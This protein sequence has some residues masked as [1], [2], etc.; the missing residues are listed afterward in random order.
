MENMNVA[1]QSAVPTSII[2]IVLD[3]IYWP[4]LLSFPDMTIRR[5]RDG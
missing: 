5:T 4:V 2:Y 1:T 3:R